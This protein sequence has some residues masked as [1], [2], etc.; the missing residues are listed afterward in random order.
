MAA[1]KAIKKPVIK[2]VLKLDVSS[3]REGQRLKEIGSF[4]YQR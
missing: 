3:K 2:Q 1:R 4:D